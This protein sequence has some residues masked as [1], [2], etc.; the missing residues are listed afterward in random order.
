MCDNTGGEKSP[1]S[2][3]KIKEMKKQDNHSYLFPSM[4]KRNVI[5]K[6]ILYFIM[7]TKEIKSLSQIDC[8]TFLG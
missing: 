2:K 7:I 3:I 1:S 4:N 5:N 6:G 8:I